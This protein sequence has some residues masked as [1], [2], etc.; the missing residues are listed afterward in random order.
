MNLMGTIQTTSI[1][2]IKYIV[3]IVDDLSRYILILFLRE[4]FK[5]FNKFKIMC[6]KQKN[7]KFESIGIIIKIRRNYGK[8]L[9][10]SKLN[11]FFDKMDI[12]HEFLT[13]KTLQ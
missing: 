13:P 9:E 1:W 11:A 3:V 2:G 7:E 12:Q 5:A 8:E 10:N 4:K 6:I